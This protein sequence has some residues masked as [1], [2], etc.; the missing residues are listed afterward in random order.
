[1]KEVYNML[2]NKGLS[3]DQFD[4]WVINPNVKK[5]YPQSDLNKIKEMWYPPKPKPK[6]KKPAPKPLDSFK[7]FNENEQ[8]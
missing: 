8:E 2:K 6:K 5:L 4:Q 1:M 7:Y 3:D